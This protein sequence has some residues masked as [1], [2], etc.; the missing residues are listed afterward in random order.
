MIYLL[1]D[2][3]G[4]ITDGLKKY[5][6]IRKEGDL[7][8]I[9]GDIGLSFAEHED[10]EEFTK[11]FLSLPY[12]IAFIDGNHENFDYLNSF[13]EENYAGGRVHRL[14]ENIMHLMRGH[15]FTFE[16]KSF[17]T[18]GGCK[19]S[20]K[21]WDRGLASAFED[22]SK[23]E[24]SL[25]YENLAAH[26]NRVDYVLTHKYK[27]EDA[28]AP[29]SLAGLSHFIENEVSFG[30]WYSGHWHAQARVDE[31][32]TFVYDNPMPILIEGEAL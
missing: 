8:I 29:L 28:A 24:I 20:K 5:E 2:P 25:A 30:H 6:A 7:L 3:H 4:V 32:H 13:P 9:L 16:G 21:W 27:L 18:M 10:F 11:E 17:F 31:K 22:P 1:S 14:S 23:E 12:P 19:S 26:G 15:I